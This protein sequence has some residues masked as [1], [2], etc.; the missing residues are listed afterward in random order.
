M[1]RFKYFIFILFS[2]L[3]S[4]GCSKDEPLSPVETA[5]ESYL[6]V[7]VS[8]PKKRTRT[9]GPDTEYGT[10][11]ESRITNMAIY[12][13]DEKNP[14]KI[15]E[16]VMLEGEDIIEMPDGGYKSEPV[17]LPASIEAGKEYLLYLVANPKKN[18]TF[19][20]ATTGSPIASFRGKHDRIDV[21]HLFDTDYM[22]MTNQHDEPE[23]TGTGGGI[24]I[25][26]TEDN[27]TEQNPAI[28]SVNLDRLAAKIVPQVAGSFEVAL[29]EEK[30]MIFSNYEFKVRSA[31]LLNAVSEFNLI[32]QWETDDDGLILRSPSW[33]YQIDDYGSNYYS[34]ID[35]YKG[36]SVDFVDISSTME[37]ENYPISS[38]FYC[39]ENNSPFYQSEEEQEEILL[40]KYKG[41]TTAVIFK[42]QL[43]EGG[44]GKTFYQYNKSFYFTPD[45]LFGDNEELS[46]NTEA[47]REQGVKVYENGYVYYTHWIT[48]QNYTQLSYAVVRNTV[49]SL[50]VTKLAGIG[51]D[52]PGGEGY[53]PGQPI[54]EI[55]SE[56]EITIIAE[57]LEWKVKE[58]E[59]GFW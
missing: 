59:H 34:T 30:D 17:L 29:T 41:L 9:T 45:D 11:E 50:T 27:K 21:A 39:L 23:D 36:G 16:V 37:G 3:F 25:K 32:Q 8:F 31:G 52:V 48:D 33:E 18:K 6:Q 42:V 54:D 19:L 53:E 56:K 12:L 35:D 20:P 28:A 14:R 22:L 46:G 7:Y 44:E 26:I 57:C 47:L 1:I 40:T 10:K 4:T 43:T 24:V 15:V 5:G 38:P 55:G 58:V 2:C 51:D 13:A 49:Y